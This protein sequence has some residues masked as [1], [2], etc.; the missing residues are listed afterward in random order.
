MENSKLNIKCA[1]I[2]QV[3]VDSIPDKTER[4]SSTYVSYG[5]RNDYPNFLYDCYTKCPS[6]QSIINRYADYVVGDGVSS[7]IISKPNPKE[8]WDELIIHLS[9]DY[10]LY[11]YA[12]IQVIRDKAN[13]PREF[14]WLDALYVRTD[15]DNET[16]Y[17]NEDFGKTYTRN[18]KTI[19]YP[20]FKRDFVQPS[21]VIMFKTPLSKGAYGLPIWHSALKSVLTEIGIDD[22]HMNEIENNFFGSAIINFNNSTPTDEEKDEIEKLVKKKFSGHQNAGRF[23]LSFNDD[24]DHSTTIERLATDDFDKRYESLAKKTQN[25]I[26]TSFGISPVLCGIVAD[27]KGFSDQDFISAY[28]IFN[29]TGVR[30]VQG[31]MV[32]VFDYIFEQKGSLEIKP[33]SIDFT[34]DNNNKDEEI[35]E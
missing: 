5:I 15:E 26:F 20:R 33:F 19:I 17:Y 22:F 24:K 35:V 9:A 7:T 29:R 4:K 2:P 8:T 1:E 32:D 30:P 6:L 18:N 14:Y 3:I 10:I 16:F 21:S 25:Q 23:L 34:D 13:R 12:F 11:G 28:K 27:G 31:K